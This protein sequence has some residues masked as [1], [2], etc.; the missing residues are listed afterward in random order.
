MSTQPKFDR[1]LI[2]RDRRQKKF[3]QRYLQLLFIEKITSGEAV[4]QVAKDFNLTEAR[5][6][7]VIRPA[8]VRVMLEK[9]W[10]GTMKLHG[11]NIPEPIEIRSLDE[12][13]AV[14]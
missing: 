3:R 7:V 11:L 2:R 5:C 9:D 4:R 13:E 14:V 8:D 6:F 1:T 12:F 10:K